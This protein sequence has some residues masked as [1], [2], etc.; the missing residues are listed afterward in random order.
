MLM[1]TKAIDRNEAAAVSLR[2]TWL[3]INQPRLGLVLG[4]ILLFAASALMLQPAAHWAN[5][6]ELFRLLRGMGMIKIALAAIGLALVWWRLASP[7][8]ASLTAVY[9]GGVW[10]LSL[11]AGLIWQLTL[12]LPASGLFHCA[13]L[14]LLAAAWRDM[15][16][17]RA[18]R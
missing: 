7:L 3:S 13:T 9:V 12:I 4:A 1:T 5:D 2:G 14:A 6:P 15:E 10:A 17:R 18:H 11:T 16:P 8:T